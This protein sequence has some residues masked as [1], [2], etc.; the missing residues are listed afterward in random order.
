MREKEGLERNE[1]YR[2]SQIS[3]ALQCDELFQKEYKA[4]AALL[5]EKAEFNRLAVSSPFYYRYSFRTNDRMNPALEE[6]LCSSHVLRDRLKEELETFAGKGNVTV[7]K[8][9]WIDAYDGPPFRR[10]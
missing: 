5:W 6:C 7:E 10:D 4:A 8:R 1:K 9:Q 2:Q 3:A